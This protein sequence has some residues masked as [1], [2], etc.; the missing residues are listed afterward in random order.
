[1]KTLRVLLICTIALAVGGVSYAFFD[2]A[3]AVVEEQA[4][5]PA[6]F[7]CPVSRLSDNSKCLDCHQMIL[8]DGKPTFG[9]KEILLSASYEQKPFDLK[10]QM[11]NGEVV[12]Y[13]YLSTINASGLA[14]IKRYYYEHPELKR[15]I[16]DIHSPGGSVF[17]A[18]KIVGIIQELQSRGIV[19]ETRAYGIALS[20]GG[21]ILIAGDIGER[22]VSPYTEI[23]IHKVWSFSMFSLDDMDSSEDKTELLKH[24]QA[25]INRLFESRTNITPEQLN[26]K[27]YKKMWWVTGTEAV[28]LGIADRLI[29]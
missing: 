22:T 16:I 20:A 5:P 10:I 7:E 13:Y 19:V 2:D 26:D 8:K 6:P 29:Q 28:E 24:L 3:E 21:M 25:N 12:G 1:M 9:L 18:W 17:F 14:A 27:T 11:E 4:A 15:L 23:M